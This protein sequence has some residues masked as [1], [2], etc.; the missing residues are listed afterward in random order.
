V[1]HWLLFESVSNGIIQ[2]Y[3]T[4]PVSGV[5]TTTLK[6]II[7]QLIFFVRKKRKNRYFYLTNGEFILIFFLEIMENSL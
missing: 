3:I 4:K 5:I 6:K 2:C 1:N 7:N